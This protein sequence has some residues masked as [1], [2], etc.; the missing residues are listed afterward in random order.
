MQQVF[1]D[2]QYQYYSKEYPFTCDFY[3]PPLDLYIEYNG[4]WTHGGRPFDETDK[5]CIE[6]LNKWKEKTRTSQ[7]YQTAVYVWS[8]LDVRKR[9]CVIK[10]NLNYL[11][12][13]SIED[14]EQWLN[15]LL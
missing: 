5:D 14:F 4:T 2:I 11:A 9:Q 8:D 3:I 6:Q 12:F 13:Y 15:N 7:F 10:N 1:P